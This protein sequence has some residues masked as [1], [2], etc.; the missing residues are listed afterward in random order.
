MKRQFS[1]AGFIG[2]SLF[3]IVISVLITVLF[4]HIFIFK[5]FSSANNANATFIELSADKAENG[6]I[7]DANS[8]IE[9]MSYGCHY[10]AINEENIARMVR[11]LPEGVTFTAV[12]L[13]KEGSPL[14]AFAPIFATLEEMGIEKDKRDAIYNSV[15]TRG[16]NLA[17]N[18]VL[19]AWLVKNDIS[20]DRYEAVR[21]S[22]AVKNRLNTMAAIT[23]YYNINATPTF[24]VN[25]RYIMTQEGTF[26]EFAQKM[27]NLIEK[28][29]QN[30]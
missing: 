27:L 17:D 19:E 16:V 12:H 25:K 30:P 9:V 29:E 6:P 21:N 18:S 22:E 7:K 28:D 13:T 10:C 20:I 5:T 23:Q 11:N 14:G 15:I 4:Y 24:I 8:I 2:Y 3:L 26:A 1:R